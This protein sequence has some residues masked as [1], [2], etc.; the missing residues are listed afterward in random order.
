MTNTATENLYAWLRDAHAMEEQGEKL[1]SGQANRLAEYHQL[2]A[3]L[4]AEANDAK[5]HQAM[6]AKRIE[7]LGSRVSIIKTVAA[8]MLAGAQN[9]SGIVVSDEPVKGILALHT[10]GQMAVGSYKILI[11]AAEAIQD[12][13][14]CKVCQALLERSENRARWIDA[15]L[16]ATTRQFLATAA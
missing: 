15:E 9:A 14:T 5:E 2:Q 11:A 3:R 7:Q 12:Q 13:E 16:N 10:F 1:F 6:L 8:K 4:Q